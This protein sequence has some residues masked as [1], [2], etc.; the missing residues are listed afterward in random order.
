MK[1]AQLQNEVLSI[2]WVD[3]QRDQF[4]VKFDEIN[5]PIKM[6]ELYYKTVLKQLQN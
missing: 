5:I 2:Q 3:K 6:N 1:Q 4:V